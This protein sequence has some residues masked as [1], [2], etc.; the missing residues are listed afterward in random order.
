MLR[1]RKDGSKK[2]EQRKKR[3]MGMKYIVRVNNIKKKA[4]SV[5]RKGRVEELNKIIRQ[6]LTIERRAL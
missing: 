2:Q 5:P 3:G 1:K 4:M 6:Y